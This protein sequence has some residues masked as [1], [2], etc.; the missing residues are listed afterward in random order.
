M[1]S[2]CVRTVPHRYVGVSQVVGIVLYVGTSAYM[3][4]SCSD[5][6]PSAT[7]AACCVW[8]RLMFVLLVDLGG[9]IYNITAALLRS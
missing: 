7:A 8:P 4:C 2:K 6:A 1:Q 5:Q 3:S 9:P